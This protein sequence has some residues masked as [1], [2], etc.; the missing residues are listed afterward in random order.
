MLGSK[1]PADASLQPM[2]NND[3]HKTM[4]C[5]FAALSCFGV[6]TSAAFL[7]TLTAGSNGLVSESGPSSTGNFV[8]VAI[9]DGLCV[10]GGD[11]WRRKE[12][13]SSEEVP[14]ALLVDGSQLTTPECK[15]QPP[16]PAQPS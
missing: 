3:Q 16:I 12:H 6:G 5:H 13:R 7:P 14:S 8:V 4:M 10:L 9:I 1:G 15:F 2:R 11:D